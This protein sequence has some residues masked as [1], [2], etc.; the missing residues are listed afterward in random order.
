M[1]CFLSLL[2]TKR[3]YN[4]MWYSTNYDYATRSDSAQAAP[5]RVSE[6]RT[7]KYCSVGWKPVCPVNNNIGR[8]LNL[9]FLT[10]YTRKSLI[11]VSWSKRNVFWMVKLLEKTCSATRR[12]VKQ[13][14]MSGF[15]QL[16]HIEPLLFHIGLWC[17]CFST[18]ENFSTL[19]VSQETTST[20]SGSIFV[21]PWCL[22]MFVLA[23]SCET[24]FT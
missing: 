22:I 9:S 17:V 23:R 16:K 5:G 2:L 20:C 7:E 18:L 24:K 15:Q 4:E 8:K 14:A 11:N 12:T 21:E 10:I 1:F 6:K 19:N 3:M 13:A